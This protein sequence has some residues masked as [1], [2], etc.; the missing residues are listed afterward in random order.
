MIQPK[1]LQ[2]WMYKESP[3]QVTALPIILASPRPDQRITTEL[4][5]SAQELRRRGA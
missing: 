4:A 2:P 3:A 1:V 5:R